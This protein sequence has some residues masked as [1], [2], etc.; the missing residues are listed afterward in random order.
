MTFSSFIFQTAHVENSDIATAV[1][2]A[3]NVGATV[4]SFVLVD[5]LGRR[6]LLVA[7]QLG[8]LLFFSVLAVAYIL[9]QYH[10]AESV[11]GYLQLYCI[12]VLILI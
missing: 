10:I 4:L 7:S 9:I 1:V 6:T 11:M 2:G 5:R 3:V 12:H 8:E